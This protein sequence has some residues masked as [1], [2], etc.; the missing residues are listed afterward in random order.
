MEIEEFNSFKSKLELKI[1]SS[2]SS[3]DL[4]SI[5]FLLKEELSKDE[6]I[7]FNFILQT[8][9]CGNFSSFLFIYLFN[10]KLSYAHLNKN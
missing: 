8:V 2:S 4:F 6:L 7:L 9:N 3:T 10:L 1:L 5:I